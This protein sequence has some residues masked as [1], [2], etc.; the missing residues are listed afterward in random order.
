[1]YLIYLI[2]DPN[3]EEKRRKKLAYLDKLPLPQIAE[4]QDQEHA[5]RVSIELSMK[6]GTI[7]SIIGI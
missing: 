5:I 1:M 6:K 7:Y 3:Y 2:S 4:N